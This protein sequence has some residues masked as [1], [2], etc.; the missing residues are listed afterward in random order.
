MNFNN[1]I[2]SVLGIND[3]NQIGEEYLCNCIFCD[4]VKY[5]LQ[6]NISKKVYHCWVCNEG[7]SLHNLIYKISG[8]SISRI[9]DKSNEDIKRSLKSVSELLQ[10]KNI[11]YSYLDFTKSKARFD[12]WKERGINTKTVRSLYLGFDYY[13]NRLVIPIFDESK[14]CAGLIRRAIS[15]DQSPKYLYNKGFKKNSLLYHLPR[16]D[17]DSY[18]ILVEGQI[19][20]IKLYQLGYSATSIM[21]VNLSSYA[22]NFIKEHYQR[23]YLMLDNDK[24]GIE[25]TSVISKK[26]FSEGLDVYQVE[27]LTKDAGELVDKSQIV[28]SHKFTID[29]FI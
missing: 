5:N 27:Y 3:Y 12:F 14:N 10:P 20:A 26:F 7:G 28:N 19:D 11:K 9:E 23:I 6:I 15:E 8:K 24:A 17:N 1:S 2:F 21:G 22:F 29:N 25:A 13:T 16:N 18:T 4:D